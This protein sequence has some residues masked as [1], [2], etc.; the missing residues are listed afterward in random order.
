MPATSP[1]AQ[2]SQPI[3]VDR[4]ASLVGTG[5]A[6]KL[7]VLD[8]I[9]STNTALIQRAKAGSLPDYTVLTAEEQTAGQGR[10]ARTWQSPKHT[11]LATSFYLEPEHHDFSW[12]VL[13]LA[14]AAVSAA[15]AHGVPAAIK[16]P[17]DIIAV[18]TAAE[19]AG[20][21]VKLGGVLAQLLSPTQLVVGIGLNVLATP[22]LPEPA[23][24]PTQPASF[25]DFIQQPDR[26]EILAALITNFW[27][28]YR[29]FAQA[30]QLGSGER[31]ARQKVT[32]TMSTL[33]QAVTV[34]PASGQPFRGRAT[35]LGPQAEL[36]VEAAD[37]THTLTSADITHLRPAGN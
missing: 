2:P 31:W 7:E 15:R 33:G 34:T 36:I 25:A 5:L 23:S 20:T 24:A 6:E 28:N 21:V 9:D 10:L 3:D 19:A 11:S 8:S 13:L 35:D 26:T 32:A 4:L 30:E 12:I 37:G 17:N 14:E 16:W 27:D 1:S 29:G 18:D 22:V